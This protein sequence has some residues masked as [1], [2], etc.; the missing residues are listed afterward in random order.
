MDINHMKYMDS[1][2]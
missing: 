1:Q 2:E